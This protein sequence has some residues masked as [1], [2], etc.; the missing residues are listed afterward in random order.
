MAVTDAATDPQP[1]DLDADLNLFRQ[2][3]NKSLSPEA[4]HA[5]FLLLW[6]RIER[7][8]RESPYA[9]VGWCQIALNALLENAG[10]INI[11]KV[12]RRIVV[13]H[14][15]VPDLEAAS[16]C[17]STM[18]SQV[19]QHPLSRYMAYSVALRCRNESAGMS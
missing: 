5:V 10:Q 17:L 7:A 11:G 8:D 9:V 12:Q 15:K 16:K 18:S 2:I 3:W 19:K 13:H 6:K 4:A 14:L 1:A